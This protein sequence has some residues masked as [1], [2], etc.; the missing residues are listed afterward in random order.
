VQQNPRRPVCQTDLAARLADPQQLGGGLIV[1][2]REHHAKGR[3]DRVG[4]A[5]G[6][7]QR[8][9]IGLPEFNGQAFGRCQSA[10]APA[11]SAH[12]PSK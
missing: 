12:N 4:G 9:G 5:V 1:I 8:L 2:G 10:T 3:D 6:E 7:R 11:S